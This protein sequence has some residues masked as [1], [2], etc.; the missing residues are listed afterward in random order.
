[1][2]HHLIVVPFPY[3][4]VGRARLHLLSS[5]TLVSLLTLRRSSRLT[6]CYLTCM[7]SFSILVSK[8]T[9]KL[10]VAS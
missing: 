1:M 4:S 10:Y 9:V 7:S 3:N 6:E 2:S 5:L 8:C